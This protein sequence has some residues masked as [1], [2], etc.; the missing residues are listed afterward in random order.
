M[1]WLAAYIHTRACHAIELRFADPTL[2]PA[3]LAKVLNVSTRTLARSF[4]S[5]NES[6]MRRVFDERVRRAAHLLKSPNATCRT[7]TDIAFACGFNDSSH[8]GRVFSARM[9]MTPT[10]WRVASAF[11]AAK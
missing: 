2:T 6:V 11:K 7:T 1:G 5:R 8:F 9:H 4:A 10:Q 3:N